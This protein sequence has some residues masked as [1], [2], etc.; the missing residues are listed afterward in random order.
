VRGIYFGSYL[1][2]YFREKEANNYKE[3]DEIERYQTHEDIHKQ[4]FM[5]SGGNERP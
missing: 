2:Q 3:R 4:I 5:K 1:F